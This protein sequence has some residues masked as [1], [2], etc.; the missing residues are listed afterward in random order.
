MAPCAGVPA[1]EEEACAQALVAGHGYPDAREPHAKRTGEQ[2]S[3]AE[4]GQPGADNADGYREADIP[5]GL[6]RAAH[7]YI[8]GAAQLKGYL[9]EHD[10]LGQGYD[11]GVLREKAAKGLRKDKKQHRYQS[12]DGD[13]GVHRAADAAVR[14]LRVTPP[15]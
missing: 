15:I 13:G 10:G 5:A 12:G 9:D 14:G 2:H 1:P 6:Q 3:P 4:S 7:N 11:L 8:H